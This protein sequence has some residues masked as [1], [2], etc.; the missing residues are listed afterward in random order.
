MLDDLQWA[1]KGSLELMEAIL[2]PTLGI[3]TGMLVAGTVRGNEVTVHHPLSNC[4][5]R[6]EVRGIHII[7]IVVNPLSLTAISQLIA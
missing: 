7:T 1:D 6:L 5:R 2:T 3:G 4:L